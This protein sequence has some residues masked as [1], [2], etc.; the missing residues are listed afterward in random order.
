MG[1]ICHEKNCNYHNFIASCTL[2]GCSEE[3]GQKYLE[4][5][6]VEEV[7]SWLLNTCEPDNWCE[8]YASTSVSKC[9][10]EHIDVDLLLEIPSD[11]LKNEMDSK[12]FDIQ[13]CSLQEVYVLQAQSLQNDI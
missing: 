12:I 10:A 1:T 5:K 13:V 11:E 8:P 7:E 6:L 2:I 9:V 4:S 3:V